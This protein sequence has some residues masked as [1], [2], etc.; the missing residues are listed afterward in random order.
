MPTLKMLK[1]LYFFSPLLVMACAN[2]GLDLGGPEEITASS[3]PTVLGTIQ[4]EVAQVRVD[5][6]RLYWL[7]SGTTRS[8]FANGGGQ[9][10][11]AGF[12]GHPWALRGCNKSDCAATRV[13]YA[14]DSVDSAAGFGLGEGVI[15][16]FQLVDLPETYWP[17]EKLV[18][19]DPVASADG[20]L[21]PSGAPSLGPSGN[22]TGLLLLPQGRPVATFDGD[23]AYFIRDDGNGQDIVSIG[24]GPRIAQHA[25]QLVASTQGLVR[26][27][28]TQGDYVYWLSA[29][30]AAHPNANA[31]IQRARKEGSG[32]IEQLVDK[33]QTAEP[34]DGEE[35]YPAGGLALDASYF[36]WVDTAQGG[37]IERCALAGCDGKP[38]I[39]ASQ[40]GTPMAL[41][42]DHNQLFWSSRKD[43]STSFAP[44]YALSSC[45]HG[46]CGSFTTVVGSLETPAAVTTDEQYLYAAS[47]DLGTGFLNSRGFGF[48][49][50]LRRF[51]K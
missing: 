40:V 46:E 9:E 3:D 4:E 36:Y 44:G 29:P 42:V 41:Q 23:A 43:A 50:S 31:S 1:Q 38:E 14:R 17:Y 16:W 5:G 8:A 19:C 15:Y 7:G 47:D 49:N 11:K 13:T 21:G 20:C 51:S 45:T 26:A 22:A 37:V 48:V 2:R 28:A 12:A 6:E 25:P 33:V 18:M 35:G 34:A 32:P 24:L 30:D 10:S 27:L 39:V